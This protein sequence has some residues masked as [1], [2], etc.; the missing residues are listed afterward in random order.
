MPKTS[1]ISFRIAC[2]SHSDSVHVIVW[3]AFFFRVLIR[4]KQSNI[5]L[6]LVVVIHLWF[7]LFLFWLLRARALSLSLSLSLG[8]LNGLFPCRRMAWDWLMSSCCQM[9]LLVVWF[10]EAFSRWRFRVWFLVHLSHYPR[11]LMLCMSDFLKIQFIC[12][13][14]TPVAWFVWIPFGNLKRKHAIKRRL[15]SFSLYSIF[16]FSSVFSASNW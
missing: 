1:F 15:F 2:F 9:I 5:F 3:L 16:L 12:E 4:I 13:T 14:N 10:I 6:L 8:R 7:S 11:Y